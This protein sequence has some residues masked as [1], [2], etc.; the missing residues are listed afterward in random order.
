MR[1]TNPDL[2]DLTGAPALPY[3]AEDIIAALQEVVLPERLARLDEVAAA[4]VSSVT[5]VLES[6]I[7]PH[8]TAAVMRTSDAHGIGEVHMIE[9]GTKPLLAKRVTRGCERWMDVMIHGST[10]PCVEGLR[11]RGYELWLADMSGTATLEQVALRPKVALVFG[12]EHLGASAEMRAACTGTFA[13][14]M[15]GMV[16][17]LNV[18]VAAGI[19]LHAVTK[20]RPGDL[21]EREVRALR[22]R[23]LM[24]SVRSPELVIERWRK[25][26]GLP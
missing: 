17:S 25:T 20:D 4:R 1:R 18:S 7:D 21:G 6:V 8:N 13:V 19:A 10:P 24:E 3:P 26:R 11:A 15:R 23:F 22:A 9:Q 5:V 16:E 12:N 14:P 2:S